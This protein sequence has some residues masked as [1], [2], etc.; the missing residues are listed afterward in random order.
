M[1]NKEKSKCI[2][3]G[4]E[5]WRLIVQS[6]TGHGAFLAHLIKWKD[7][8]ST[9]NVCMEELQSAGHLI[10]RCPALS[11][12]KHQEMNE[13]DEEFRILKFM[14][15]KKNKKYCVTKF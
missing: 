12:E 3:L 5:K 11:Y 7:I 14:K 2:K 13:E 1:L 9:C 15:C 6:Y 10:N 4:S 8:S